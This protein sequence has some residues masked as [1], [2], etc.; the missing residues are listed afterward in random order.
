MTVRDKYERTT[1][2]CSKCVVAC[3]HMPGMLAPG[4]LE[5]LCPLD[6]SPEDSDAWLREH[7]E[8]SPGALVMHG[9]QMMR[10]HTIVPKLAPGGCVFLKEQ[11]CTVHA[12]APFGCAFLDMHMAEGPGNQRVR[13]ALLAIIDDFQKGGSYSRAWIR[14]QNTGN[15]AK[16]TEE[17]RAKLTAAVKAIEDPDGKNRG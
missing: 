17:R 10:I 14:L 3:E 9:S 12:K 2:A 13:D 11:R 1:C 4:D 15:T 8:A 6:L 5:L 7:F 16:P